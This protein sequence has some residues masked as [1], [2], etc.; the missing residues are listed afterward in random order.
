MVSIRIKHENDF[1]FYH[2]ALSLM[3]AKETLDWMMNE[4]ILKHLILPEQKL[5][6]GTRYKHSPTG[7]ASEFNALDSNCNHN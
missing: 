2:G 7:N 6:K 5:N 3:T 1:F 4:G